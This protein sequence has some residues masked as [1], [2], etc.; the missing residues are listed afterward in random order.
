MSKD[1]ASL[2]NIY[3]AIRG[4]VLNQEAV[5]WHFPVF[6]AAKKKA[7][8]VQLDFGRDPT[9]DEVVSLY[10]A[11]HR[12]SGRDDWAPAFVPGVGVRV[13]NFAGP[14]FDK[15]TKLWSF[16]DKSGKTHKSA[17]FDEVDAKAHE[18]GVSNRA[19][20]KL[21]KEATQAD[22]VPDFHFKTFRSEGDYIGN[23]WGTAP[24]GEQYK[25]IIDGQDTKRDTRGTGRSDLQGWVESELRPRAERVNQE[26]ARKYGWDKPKFSPE[27]SDAVRSQQASTRS[28]YGRS[29]GDGATAGLP[30]RAHQKAGREGRIDLQG[31]RFSRVPRDHLTGV[32][33]G[34]GIKAA[35]AER[36]RQAT[37]S[38]IKSRLYAYVD[39]G[40]GVFP[41]AGLGPYK[42]TVQFDNLYDL[43]A[44][45]LGIRAKTPDANE[46]ESLILDAGFDGVYVR[47]AFHRQG[48]AIL[49]G[50]APATGTKQGYIS[51]ATIRE[52]LEER[53]ARVS[54]RHGPDSE[55]AKDLKAQIASLGTVRHP[56]Q[57]AA[58]NS[59]KNDSYHGAVLNKEPSSAQTDPEPG[60]K[61]AR[62]AYERR[63]ME[64]ASREP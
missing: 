12:L 44:D 16:K 17:D 7:N 25:E 34:A 42:H 3:A 38:R 41:E 11:I 59:E 15:E 45:P 53:L 63:I 49:L 27:R 30:G 61:A 58:L 46:R 22:G 31:A 29:G 18:E 2:L 37:D 5:V 21:V 54:E 4:L 39:E 13:L 40:Q 6:D 19:F 23:D 56:S 64:L 14:Q 57:L 32:F 62:E 10:N 60:M 48:V 28:G 36:V 35:E 1:T 26:F 43:V 50:Q 51:M 8:G 33:F 47:R 20:Q 55:S 24:K 52:L 9:H